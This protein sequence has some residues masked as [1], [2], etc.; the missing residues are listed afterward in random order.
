MF[1]HTNFIQFWCCLQQQPK[2]GLSNLATTVFQKIHR[3]LPSLDDWTSPSCQEP[4]LSQVKL[5]I[6]Q[7][8]ERFQNIPT[9]NRRSF[10]IQNWNVADAADFKC[11]RYT[12]FKRMFQCGPTLPHLGWPFPHS[13]PRPEFESLAEAVSARWNLGSVGWKFKLWMEEMV[14]PIIII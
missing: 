3:Y 10:L 13:A 8:N 1:R 2:H 5:K 9:V 7:L 4:L 6:L 12:S 14:Y 11:S